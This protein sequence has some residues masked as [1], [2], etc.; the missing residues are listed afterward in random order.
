VA[1]KHKRHRASVQR[2]LDNKEMYARRIRHLLIFELFEPTLRPPFK[3][4]DGV[5]RKERMID[6]AP[7]YPDQIIHTL[8]VAAFKP[9][10]MKGM[11]EFCS[12]C[13]PGRGVHYGKKYV[14]RWLKNDLKNT[15]YF[16]KLDIRKYYPSLKPKVVWSLLCRK[17]KDSKAMRV[18]KK[19]VFAYPGLPIGL[20]TSQWLA[21]FCL[22]GLDHYIKEV[23]HIPYYIRY[24]DDM[25]LFSDDKKLLHKARLKI[26][27]YLSKLGLALK[28]NWQVNKFDYDY[29]TARRKGQDLDFM[30]FRFFRD[31]TIIRK[32]ISLRIRRR[33]KKVSK[34]TNP[35]MKDVK[36]VLSYLGWVKHTD[37]YIFYN[38]TFGK[39]LSIN[40][41]RKM[42]SVHDR[43]KQSTTSEVQY[44]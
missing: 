4:I 20:L 41:L 27:C 35:R 12:A 30:G 2:V 10:F 15:R 21:N 38:E 22:Q 19:I 7:F 26:K 33:V 28:S 18:L 44:C 25:V 40:K 42:V 34:T 43:K 11:Y 5:S 1:S 17:F 13:V 31:K 32:A 16:L 6:S 37:S 14:E 29:G 9:Y 8:L 23:L 24:L 3:I 36:A 39:Y